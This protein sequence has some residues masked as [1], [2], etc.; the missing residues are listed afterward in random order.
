MEEVRDEAELERRVVQ[1]GCPIWARKR[2][3]RAHIAEVP[4]NWFLRFMVGEKYGKG[5]RKMAEGDG[6]VVL[7]HAPT[8]LSAIETEKYK[9]KYNYA[10]EPKLK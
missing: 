9:R 7:Y 8:V 5:W 3:I 6:G 2:S 10:A 1:Y 4:D